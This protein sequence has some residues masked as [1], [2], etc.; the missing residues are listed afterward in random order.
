MRGRR[1]LQCV[2]VCCSV[3]QCVAVCCSDWFADVGVCTYVH[4]NRDVWTQGVAVCCSVLQC[5]AVIVLQM[6]VCVHMCIQTEMC[7]PSP[8]RLFRPS[9][10][11]VVFLL[12]ERN[13]LSQCIF[14][15]PLKFCNGP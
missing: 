2:A 12:L 1:G 14:R 13:R 9:P 5:V 7:G 10:T 6:W 15:G 11:F 3:L 4:P 8:C